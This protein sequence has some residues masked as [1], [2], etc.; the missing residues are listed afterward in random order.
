MISKYFVK[1]MTDNWTA[2]TSWYPNQDGT[3][4]VL[5]RAPA[6]R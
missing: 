3:V 6:R 2:P 5:G 4:V 1:G